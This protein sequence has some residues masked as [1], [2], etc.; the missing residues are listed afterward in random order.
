MFLSVSA[1]GLEAAEAD[2]EEDEGEE[3]EEGVGG[4]SNGDWSAAT[5]VLTTD[6]V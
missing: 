3:E 5:A 1:V 4:K 6:D 2:A